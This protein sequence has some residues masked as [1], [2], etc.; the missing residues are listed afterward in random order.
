MLMDDVEVQS[1]CLPHG[2]HEAVNG[3]VTPTGHGLRLPSIEYVRDDAFPQ[4]MGNEGESAIA[5][6]V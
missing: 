2:T 4:F 3:S 6:E 5:L 1:G